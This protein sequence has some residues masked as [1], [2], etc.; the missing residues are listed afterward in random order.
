MLCFSLEELVGS[1]LA[2][3]LTSI[4]LKIILI[5]TTFQIPLIIYFMQNL[6]IAIGVNKL[7]D[8]LFSV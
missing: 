6:K 5:M 4:F 7:S 8:M 2:L 1:F 3:A